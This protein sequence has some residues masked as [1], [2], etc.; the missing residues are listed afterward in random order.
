MSTALKQDICDQHTPG[1]LVTDV[2]IRKVEQSLPPDVQYACL[3]WVQHL[4]RSGMQLHDDGQVH[5]FLKA[6]FLHWLEALSWMRKISEGI[7]AITSLESI[8]LVSVSEY[9]TRYSTNLPFRLG[10]VRSYMHLSM[11]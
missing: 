11:I 5:Q 3:Y 7:L 10:I 4:Q 1:V 9:I 6:Y 8:A 2:E